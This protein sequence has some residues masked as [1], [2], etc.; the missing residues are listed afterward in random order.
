MGYGLQLHLLFLAIGLLLGCNCAAQE[1]VLV[2]EDFSTNDR[3][4]FVGERGY[5]T[6]SLKKKEYS[7]DRRSFSGDDVFTVDVFLDPAKDFSIESTLLIEEA[8]LE[9]SAGIIWNYAD[10]NNFDIFFISKDGSFKVCALRYGNLFEVSEGFQKHPSIKGVG[11]KNTLSV[12]RKGDNYLYFI[13]DQQVFT[14]P[15]PGLSYTSHGVFTSSKIKCIFLSFRILQEQQINLIKEFKADKKTLGTAVNSKIN[16]SAPLISPDGSLL[17]FSREIQGGH[18]SDIWMCRRMPDG[19]WSSATSVGY[20]LNNN[21]YNSVISCS[22]DNK[23]ILLLNT[24]TADGKHK[25]CCFSISH[26]DGKGW[27]VPRD[28]AIENLASYGKWLDAVLA[29]DNETMLLSIQRPGGMG[30][31]DLYVSF[32]DGKGKW[33]EPKNLG[34]TIN[35]MF[36]EASPFLASDNKTLYFCSTGYPGY[37]NQDIFM[38]RRLD[39][40]WTNWSK[41]I[42]LG[43]SINSAGFD[44]FFSIAAND[45]TAYLVSSANSIGGTDIFR[46]DL[47]QELLPAKVCF[48]SGKVL[49]QKNN[50]PL[51]AQLIYRSLHHE[52][53]YGAVSS[54]EKTGSFQVVLP[55]VDTYYI[56]A[57]K[58][59]YYA[60]ADSITF[61]GKANETLK[62]QMI[63]RLDPLSIGQSLLI[64][65]LYFEKTKA[66]FLP[67]SL[68]AL[69]NLY[70]LMQQNPTM[71]IEIIGHTDNV[72]DPLLNQELSVQRAEAVVSY[73]EKKGIEK[74]RMISKGY[75][76]SNP[77]AD[78]AKEETRRLNRRV[79]LVVIAN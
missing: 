27:S 7:I 65:Q 25:G 43:P 62:K 9:S 51:Q 33:R 8:T 73:L 22:T 67:I 45:S 47:P 1:A 69:D 40:S 24:Y 54:D 52:E 23:S 64:R 55:E 53:V 3:Y 44:A 56:T 16:D 20:P 21:N 50:A 11:K 46:M 29:S 57:E 34:H 10:M 13:N 31:N 19:E 26:F 15:F 12:Q 48:L 79:E 71:K 17:F 18:N 30:Y 14:T 4:W 60:Q 61:L 77:I 28:V 36:N 38:S 42:N 59:G 63:I 32:Y 70:R 74:S 37:G 72:G 66:E 39:D 6:V 78:N 58:K 41:P 2:N 76:G 5:T 35:T 49:D 68:P 75:G